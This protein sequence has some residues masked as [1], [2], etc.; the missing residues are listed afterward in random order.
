MSNT[1]PEAK[2]FWDSFEKA[3]KSHNLPIEILMGIACRESGFGRLL[4]RNGF[5]DRGNAFG[6]MQVEC[7]VGKEFTNVF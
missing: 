7:Q 4:D 6:I 1:F 5:G 3:A 2:L